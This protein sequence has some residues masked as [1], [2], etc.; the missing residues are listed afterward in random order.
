[1]TSQYDDVVD[2]DR[3]PIDDQGSPA[4]YSAHSCP[5]CPIYPPVTI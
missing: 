4:P 3:Y 1:M 2:L 5:I